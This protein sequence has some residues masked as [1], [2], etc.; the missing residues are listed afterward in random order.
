MV[1][2]Y[3]SSQGVNHEGSLQYATGTSDHLRLSANHYRLKSGKWSG[4]GPLDLVHL[5]DLA[6]V[7]RVNFVH[8]LTGISFDDGVAVSSVPTNV[9]NLYVSLAVPSLDDQRADAYSKGAT[10][11][12][13]ASPFKSSAGLLENLVSHPPKVPG[14]TLGKAFSG[15]DWRSVKSY[16]GFLRSVGKEYLNAAFGWIPL[17]G[18]ITASVKA[19]H[20]QAT[21]YEALKRNHAGGYR[22]RSTVVAPNTESETTAIDSPS[23]AIF[24]G[25][26]GCYGAGLLGAFTPSGAYGK[27]TY[28]VTNY[29]HSWFVGRYHYHLP[30]PPSSP[31]SLSLLE[32]L[33]GI[34][35]PK[36]LWDIMPWSWLIDYG[37]NFGDVV[38]N[39]TNFLGHAQWTSYA[40]IMTT[41]RRTSTSHI[42]V[43]WTNA[44]TYLPQTTRFVFEHMREIETKTRYGATPMGFSTS[45]GSLSDY[46]KGILAAVGISRLK[47]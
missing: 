9:D 29:E 8:N 4:G 14:R 22:R 42:E 2:K 45:Y 1:Q 25:T 17:V 18:D 21:K 38:S 3:R 27:Q 35:S 16:V 10:G 37:T 23:L 19:Y 5:R 46:Q 31:V 41:K 13:R 34:P 40:F 26:R 32:Q 11:Y 15:A 12:A 6:I 47:F 24:Q 33:G 30:S 39:V 43:G 20:R 28:T 44:T 36:V 7:P